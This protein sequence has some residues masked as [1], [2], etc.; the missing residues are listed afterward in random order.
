MR[1]PGRILL[2]ALLGAAVV[3][4]RLAGAEARA[5]AIE[6]RVPAELPGWARGT[7]IV[8][9]VDLRV[10]VQR[11]GRAGRVVVDPYTVRGD[12]LTRRLR[13]SFDSA[14]VACVRRW[15]F[16]PAMRD[17]RPVAAWM[18]VAVPFEDP[19]SDPDSARADTAS[20]ASR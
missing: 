12:I 19:G 16:R 11:D 1:R 7:G 8:T 13:A 6:R 14:A 15:R 4:A 3:P 10:R 20:G 17:G 18:R 5:P 2:A 9:N